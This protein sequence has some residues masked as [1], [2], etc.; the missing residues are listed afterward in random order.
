MTY[1]AKNEQD[2]LLAGVEK[3]ASGFVIAWALLGCVSA[4]AETRASINTSIAGQVESNPYLLSGPNTSAASAVVTVSPGVKFLDGSKTIGIGATYRRSEYSR[5]YSSNND[6]SANA[7]ISQ[8]LSPRLDYNAD[9]GFNSAIVGAND[10]LTF[11]ANPPGGGAFPPL[12]GDIAITG[13]RQRRQSFTGGLG[14]GYTASAR[15]SFQVQGGFSLVRYPSGSVASEYDSTSGS[16]GY[17]RILNSRTSVGFNVGVSLADY[18]KTTIGDATTISPQLTFSTKFGAAWSASASLGVSH[19]KITG[20]LGKYTQNSASGNFNLCN[21]ASTGK[22]C[23]FARRSVQPTS[24]GVTVRPQTSIGASYNVRLDVKSSID[25][26]ANFSRSGQ[27]SQVTLPSNGSVDYGQANLRY[28]RRLSQRLQGNL[29][30]SYADSYR[31]TIPRKANMMF[32]FGLS[33]AFGDM[34]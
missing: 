11:G 33:Y 28:S 23:L 1:F 19:S 29:T 31:D 13:L 22:F 7:S 16:F 15:D 14:L 25:A 27:I 32:G 8:K 17:S 20:P 21:T 34:R 24:F 4:H 10:L 2:A 6:I 18:R 5:R 30:A 26:S 9:L 12:P 3:A